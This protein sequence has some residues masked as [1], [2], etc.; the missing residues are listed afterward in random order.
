MYLTFVFALQA[1]FYAR[2]NISGTQRSIEDSDRSSVSD[3]VRF[4][5]Y[6]DMDC[7]S[8]ATNFFIQSDNTWLLVLCI[9]YFSN[10]LVLTSTLLYFRK[11]FLWLQR[12]NEQIKT[13][14]KAS[15]TVL[16]CVNIIALISDLSII[17]HDSVQSAADPDSDFSLIILAIMFPTKIMQ[18]LLILILETPVACFN[19]KLLNN[20]NQPNTRCQRFA[21]AF[22][23]CQIIWFVHRLVNDA[24]IAVIFFVLAP[25]QTLGIV[26]LLLATIASAI[27]FVVIFSRNFRGYNGQICTH[28]I[29]MILNGQIVCG[30]LLAITL[31]FMVLVDNGLNSAGMGGLILSLVLPLAMLI[32]GLIIKK[33]YFTTTIPPTSVTATAEPRGREPNQ[34]TAIQMDD[35]E[36]NS[37]RTPLLLQ[38][39]ARP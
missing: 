20:A 11:V 22:A 15:A 2:P 18:V 30:L 16:T 38:V 37:E 29:C 36:G 35:N 12:Q 31:L 39:R 1:K 5:Q 27:A 28:M 13:L 10:L 21:H 9:F 14:Y 7:H 25:A 26:T 4:S 6:Y 24:I 32:T 8:H 33:K 17:I 34:A 3:G 23:L 19:T